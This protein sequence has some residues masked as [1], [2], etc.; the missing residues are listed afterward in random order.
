MPQNIDSHFDSERSKKPSTKT[1]APRYS[2]DVALA[3]AFRAALQYSLAKADV[4]IAQ[5]HAKQEF[6]PDLAE[7]LDAIACRL[8][9]YQ[10]SLRRLLTCVYELRDDVPPALGQLVSARME[11]N[12]LVDTPRQNVL[13]VLG[14][15]NRVLGL[16]SLRPAM[17]LHE[18]V[19]ALTL[20]AAYLSQ[21]HDECLQQ[22]NE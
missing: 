20:A 22:L 6:S 3:Q 4:P 18:Q 5:K 19:E 10:F 8:N 13:E 7:L 17:T 2:G 21:I 14:R 1:I 16:H 9:R 11:A 15:V 12:C